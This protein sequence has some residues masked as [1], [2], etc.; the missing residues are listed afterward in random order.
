MKSKIVSTIGI[1][2][3][4]SR[5]FLGD[6]LTLPLTLVVSVPCIAEKS[7]VLIV[8]IIGKSSSTSRMSFGHS[9]T[10]SMYLFQV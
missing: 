10:H 8:S 1:C 6:S 5:T 2:S 7:A 3:M 9:L 4:T